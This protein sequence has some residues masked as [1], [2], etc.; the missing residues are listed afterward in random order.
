MNG[1]TGKRT[2]MKNKLDERLCYYANSSNIHQV[3]TLRRNLS[4][5]ESQKDKHPKEYKETLKR[6]IKFL[7]TCEKI[8]SN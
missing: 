3:E 8:K 6:V 5:R 2:N 4:F 7:K 1:L